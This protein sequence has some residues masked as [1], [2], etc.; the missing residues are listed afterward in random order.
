MR[1]PESLAALIDLG[2]IEEVVRPLMSGK[3]AQVYLVVSEG[4]LRVAKV[5]RTAQNRT[6]RQR[7]EYTE[8]RAVRNTRTQRAMS[9]RSAYGR[10][11]D[12]ASWRS[13][14]VDTIYQLSAAGVRVPEPHHFVDGSLVME[15]VTDADGN[16]AQRLADLTIGPVEA[17]AVFATL[18]SSVTKML[19]AGVVHGDLSAFN[20]LMG[21]DGPVLIDFPQAVDP[22]H[23]K[24]ARKLLV[25]DV[26]NLSQFLVGVMPGR[27]R[28]P[29]GQELWDLYERN[30]L[31]PETQLTGRY[32]PP[33]RKAD[34]SAVLREIEEVAEEAQDRRDAR[35]PV[36]GRRRRRNS[37][38]APDAATAPA[39]ATKPALG[40][41]TTTLPALGAG[42]G[43]TT[44]DPKANPAPSRARRR[45]GRRRRAGVAGKATAC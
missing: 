13:V 12:E 37:K 34:D 27:R 41:L 11:Q 35:A 8:G 26:D 29:Y 28:L 31:T 1:Q 7:A 44:P 6:F 4:E 2:L 15:L 42:K 36:R 5:Y 32:E 9:K 14:E 17:G 38:R 39:V 43:G 24:N 10:A 40:V 21:H 16:P 19:C 30:Q 3:E 45:R 25:R 18:L 22:A 23:N 20:V 33:E